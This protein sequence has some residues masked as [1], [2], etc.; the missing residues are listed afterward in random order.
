[1][2]NP[3][4]LFY[5]S[6][7]LVG[8]MMMENDHIGMYIKLL[9]LQHQK[10]VLTERDMLRVCGEYIE[11][12]FTKFEKDENGNYYNKR[13]R[14]EIERRES[15]VNGR[16]SNRKSSKKDEQENDCKQEEKFSSISENKTIEENNSN[17][18]EGM[19]TTNDTTHDNTCENH[20]TIICETHV[21]HMENENEN[22]N[23][24]EIGIGKENESKIPKALTEEKGQFDSRNAISPPVPEK[25]TTNNQTVKEIYDL[26]P[27]R[28][29]K[30]GRST[31]KSTKDMDKIKILLKR[32]VDVRS[33]I[34]FYV[35]DCKKTGTYMKNFSTFLNNIPDI[36]ELKKNI[37]Q[38]SQQKNK[39]QSVY[40]HTM[41]VKLE[42]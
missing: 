12:V 30:D 17:H 14:E 29:L 24:N 2:N 35:S 15:Y 31:G 33:A 42:S 13:M 8:T 7:F 16:R 11:D 37:P 20:M 21:E 9:C 19:N 23:E 3:A 10:S 6:D 34:E 32:G 4:V 5:T 28:C 25:T 38:I 1:M 40:E 36:E 27:A 41:G 22:E 26:Y 39:V 18:L